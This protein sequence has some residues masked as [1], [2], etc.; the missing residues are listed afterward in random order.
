MTVRAARGLAVAGQ[1]LLV[2]G[3]QL[4][5][6]VGLSAHR[7]LGDVG[8]HPAAPLPAFVGAS[9]AP[10]VHCSPQKMVW[11]ESRPAASVRKAITRSKRMWIFLDA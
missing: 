9:N 10:L 1:I 4:P 11:A 5:G 3:G 6:V 2:V 7:E 8:H